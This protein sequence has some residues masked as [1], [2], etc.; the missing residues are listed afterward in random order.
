MVPWLEFWLVGFWQE[1]PST[2]KGTADVTPCPSL[3]RLEGT[4]RLHPPP[5]SPSSSGETQ[6]QWLA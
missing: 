1:G 2:R 6:G 4:G 5:S 3:G